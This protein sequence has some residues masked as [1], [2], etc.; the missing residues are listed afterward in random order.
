MSCKSKKGFQEGDYLKP[1]PGKTQSNYW[2]LHEVKEVKV[3]GVY[4]D[5]ANIDV[6]LIHGYTN[7]RLS[8]DSRTCNY[9]ESY[10]TVHDR[11]FMYS[12]K[13]EKDTYEIF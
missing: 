13:L 9:R 8:Y 12:R 11:M 6:I 7:N 2:S 1:L 4:E 5:T 3:I 10:F